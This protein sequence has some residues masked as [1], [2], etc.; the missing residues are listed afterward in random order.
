MVSNTWSLL[1][2][3]QKLLD[4]LVVL[5]TKYSIYSS[6]DLSKAFTG[7]LKF[8]NFPFEKYSS[9]DSYGS[10]SFET[11]INE[12]IEYAYSDNE[13]INKVIDAMIKCVDE[14]QVSFKS[15]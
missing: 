1:K 10:L 9:D 3:L 14:V 12:L 11:W 8:K 7:Y 2:K 15:A 13:A 5:E 6:S 4:E